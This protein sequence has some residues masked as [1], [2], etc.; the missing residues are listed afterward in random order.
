MRAR[1][2]IEI[3]NNEGSLD[4]YEQADIIHSVADRVQ[5]GE[6]RGTVYD[7]FGNPAGYFRK[8]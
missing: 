7:R 3:D 2:T 6:D 5:R 4:N 1:I 8:D